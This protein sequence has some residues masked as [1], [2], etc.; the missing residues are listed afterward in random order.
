MAKH[1]N[2]PGIKEVLIKSTSI[3][4]EASV[5][6]IIPVSVGVVKLCGE[7]SSNHAHF[8]FVKF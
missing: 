7:V 1:P 8:K 5:V 2:S 3:I 4:P 6:S